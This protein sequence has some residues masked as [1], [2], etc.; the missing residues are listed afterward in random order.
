MNKKSLNNGLDV[1]IEG[2]TPSEQ[3]FVGAIL[4]T[5]LS[6]AGYLNTRH[7]ISPTQ[8]ISAEA[9]AVLVPSMLDVIRQHSPDFLNTPMIVSGYEPKPVARERRSVDRVMERALRMATTYDDIDVVELSLNRQWN[10]LSVEQKE[11]LLMQA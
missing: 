6:S 7:I 11:E 5:A 2:G 3:R 8:T 9:E 10:Q 1:K 4:G